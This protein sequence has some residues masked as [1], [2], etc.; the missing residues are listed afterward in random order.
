MRINHHRND[1]PGVGL[2]R[3]GR[4]KRFLVA[5]GLAT[6]VAV[7][8]A[9]PAFA[10][11]VRS[12]TA[13]SAYIRGQSPEGSCSY[14]VKYDFVPDPYNPLN[15]STYPSSYTL[16]VSVSSPSVTAMNLTSA[17]DQQWVTYQAQLV[18]LT[19][20]QITYGAWQANRLVSDD[21][22][23]ALPGVTHFTFGSKSYFLP[24]HTYQARLAIWWATN[25]AWTHN[26][27]LDLNNLSTL[28]HPD[29]ANGSRTSTC[30]F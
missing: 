1:G 7:A 5:I 23:T 21:S 27:V 3:H 25:G 9:T 17:R 13:R 16:D 20:G 24:S 12:F 28:G 19:T 30:S 18:D 4:V 11:T 14:N 2:H 6:S 29:I 26:A 15:Y 22:Y 10:F 8:A